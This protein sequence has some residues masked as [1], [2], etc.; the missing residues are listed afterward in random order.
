MWSIPVY[1]HGVR[2]ET[3]D[4]RHKRNL[5]RIRTEY[6]SDLSLE[7]CSYAKKA[8]VCNPDLFNPIH[9]TKEEI[10]FLVIYFGYFC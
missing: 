1:F 4:G 3:T 9:I 10:Y 6:F 7:P 2:L 5:S 8:S